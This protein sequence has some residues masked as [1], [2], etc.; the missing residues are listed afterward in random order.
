MMKTSHKT[1]NCSAFRLHQL[2]DSHGRLSCCLPI[3]AAN[4]S[5]VCRR[6]P[7]IKSHPLA[8]ADKAISADWDQ[9]PTRPIDEVYGAGE[10][11]IY[12]SYFI[13]KANQQAAK[14]HTGSSG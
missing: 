1:G 3:D 4:E 8:G 6:P 7:H 2:C 5:P 12:E 13:Q 11:D 9:T 14:G 10:L